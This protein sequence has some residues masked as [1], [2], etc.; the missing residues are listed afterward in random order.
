MITRDPSTVKLSPRSAQRN[1]KLAE[2][3][4][5]ETLSRKGF[6]SDPDNE[7][8]DKIKQA[9]REFDFSELPA[10]NVEDEKAREFYHNKIKG[11][12]RENYIYKVTMDCFNDKFNQ[13]IKD[14]SMLEQLKFRRELQ[15]LR[16]G[17]HRVT[18][19][20]LS[21]T[22]NQSVFETILNI[23]PKS[24]GESNIHSFS[25]L[26]SS[27]KEHESVKSD[28]SNREGHVDDG[29]SDL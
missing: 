5:K 12:S 25:S 16:D 3:L 11:L 27:K 22:L 23:K 24:T 18:H 2:Q 14:L 15:K 17:T 29:D 13:Q 10:D 20:V 7:I 26:K 4:R 21:K 9:Q 6:S 28:K 19:D 8:F 1:S